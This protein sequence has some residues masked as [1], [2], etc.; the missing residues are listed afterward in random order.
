MHERDTRVLLRGVD[1]DIET[2]GT[3]EQQRKFEPRRASH[4][5]TFQLP[6]HTKR[7]MVMSHANEDLVR[8]LTASENANR[9]FPI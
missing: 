6:L 7:F 4:S 9:I 5:S 1:E 2:K 3:C 8:G